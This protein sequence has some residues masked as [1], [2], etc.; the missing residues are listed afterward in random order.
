LPA[1][2]SLTAN[3][4]LIDAAYIRRSRS[5]PF[6]WEE[7]PGA[8]GYIFTL[9]RG[10]PS[11]KVEIRRNGPD[12]KTSYTLEIPDIGEGSFVWQVEAV[13]SGTN[14]RGRVL[15]R[16][17]TVDIPRPNNPRVLDTETLY[18]N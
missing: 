1:P 15:E 7:V 17:F 4:V 9:Y 14:Q 6:A 5:I 13:N 11:E 12:A 3:N 18:G 10:T 8:D 2:V 16:R